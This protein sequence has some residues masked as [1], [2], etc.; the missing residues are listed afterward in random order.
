MTENK[1]VPFKSLLNRDFEDYKINSGSKV[2]EWEYLDAKNEI[3]KEKKDMYEYIQSF[4]ASTDIVA[5]IKREEGEEH[6]KGVYM[7]VTKLGDN[8]NSIN[9]YLS[10]LVSSI[11]KELRK[12]EGIS[13]SKEVGKDSEKDAKNEFQ[14]REI[15][16]KGDIE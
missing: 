15:N 6:G 16:S 7:D 14:S 5:R 10:N 2:Y 9:E 12:N 8:P 11:Q 13:N 4:K 3:Q 1:K